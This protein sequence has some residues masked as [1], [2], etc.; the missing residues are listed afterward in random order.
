MARAMA[1]KALQQ[2]ISREEILDTVHIARF[3]MATRIIGDAE[4]CSDTFG[5]DG[6]VIDPHQESGMTHVKVFGTGPSISLDAGCCC[7]VS[8]ALAG[9]L[10]AG[11]VSPNV[12][13]C[14]HAI[15]TRSRHPHY[16][17]TMER[18]HD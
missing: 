8:I 12:R 18:T 3:G 14:P 15:S 7:G 9:K 11:S 1:D 17:D 10:A 2:G 4:P 16:Q 13:H 5:W 6:A